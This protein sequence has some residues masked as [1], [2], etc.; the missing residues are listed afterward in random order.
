MGLKSFKIGVWRILERLRSGLGCL[1]RNLGQGLSENRR[2]DEPKM[3]QV[4]AKLEQERPKLGYV[5]AKMA[6]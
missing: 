2:L 5:G 6:T 4:S 1:W 3:G